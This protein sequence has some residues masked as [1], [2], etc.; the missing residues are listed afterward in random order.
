MSEGLTWVMRNRAENAALVD[1]PAL[2]ASRLKLGPG[3]DMASCDRLGSPGT[4]PHPLQGRP[5]P[6]SCGLPA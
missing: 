2:R 1:R 3:D 4:R 5:A 6:P